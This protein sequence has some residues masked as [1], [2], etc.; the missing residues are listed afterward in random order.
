MKR[1]RGGGRKR[2]V[3]RDERE[4]RRGVGRKERNRK[5]VRQT[6]GQIER[7]TQIVVHVIIIKQIPYV[8]N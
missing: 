8:I 7:D 5:S 6:N 4:E 3:E 1:E 2:G